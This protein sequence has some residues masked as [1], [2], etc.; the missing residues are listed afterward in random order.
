MMEESAAPVVRK[1][2]ERLSRPALRGCA[3]ESQPGHLWACAAFLPQN[4]N[5]GAW[6]RCFNCN[7][8]KVLR[9]LV[10]AHV[11]TDNRYGQTHRST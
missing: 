9:A 7:C 6:R 3:L 2:A 4:Y 11:F 1:S 10:G 5:V 8:Y